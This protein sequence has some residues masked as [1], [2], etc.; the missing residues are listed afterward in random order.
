MGPPVLETP[1]IMQATAQ[2]PIKPVLIP[3]TETATF[4]I[5]LVVSIEMQLVLVAWSMRLF[6]LMVSLLLLKFA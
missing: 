6:V 5:S 4:D 2:T 3:I 1:A